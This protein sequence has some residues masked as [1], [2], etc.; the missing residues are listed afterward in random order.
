MLEADLV[1][2]DDQ[3]ITNGFHQVLIRPQDRDY[4][5]FCWRHVYYRWRIWPFGWTCSPYYFCKILRPL[6]PYLRSN[7]LRTMIYVDDILLWAFTHLMSDHK[8]LLLQCLQDL[9]FRINFEN[10]GLRLL[11]KLIILDIPFTQRANSTRW[12]RVVEWVSLIRFQSTLDF[13][14]LFQNIKQLL[15]AFNVAFKTKS[16]QMTQ[17]GYQVVI[18][19]P[20]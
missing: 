6:M 12:L 16:F 2:K 18:I 14:F 5:G 20:I 10:P 4:F 15:S 7:G 11:N 19:L 3:M 17:G 1:Q 8:D 13:A 9:G